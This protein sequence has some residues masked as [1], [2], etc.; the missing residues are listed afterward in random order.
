[1]ENAQ[2]SYID[3]LN[4]AVQHKGVPNALVRGVRYAL[5]EFLQEY[6]TL[7][8]LGSCSRHIV[9]SITNPSTKITTNPCRSPH[10]CPLCTPKW[11]ANKRS[12]IMDCLDGELSKGR[13][14][15]LVT[16]TL[17]FPEGSSLSARYKLLLDVWTSLVQSRSIKALRSTLNL[18]YIRVLEETFA[19]GFFFPHIHAFFV[20][21]DGPSA[22]NDIY[23]VS[24]KWVEIGVKRGLFP[25]AHSQSVDE[26]KKSDVSR[27]STYVTKHHYL[28]LGFDALNWN[29]SEAIKPIQLLQAA[30][31]QGDLSLLGFW[32][33]FEQSSYRLRRISQSHNFSRSLH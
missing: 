24:H 22:P 13:R 5:H 26:V 14:V 29:E 20:L 18:G 4:S 6:T 2:T 3:V 8:S 10:A 16:L 17:P 9:D 15:F 23:R 28:D 1:M 27:T 19:G 31:A 30:A 12:R 7:Q 21:D 33:E 32:S 25:K 11:L